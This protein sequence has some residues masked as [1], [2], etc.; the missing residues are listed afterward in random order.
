MAK[1][2]RGARP[3]ARLCPAQGAG[4]RLAGNARI[5]AEPAYRRLACRRA[6]VATLH[7]DPDRH[8]PDRRRG[9]AVPVADG[10]ARRGRAR[11]QDD[12]Q[13][14]RRRTRQRDDA[15]RRRAANSTTGAPRSD[16][17]APASTARWA[18]GTC[19]RS[20]TSAFKIVAV[21]P[22]ATGWEGQTL[23]AIVSGGQPL[24]MFGERAGVMEV[25]IDGRG[26]VR[27]AQ[28]DRRP[29]RALPRR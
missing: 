11:R 15:V 14:R 7:P 4:R 5:I 18:D 12:P 20:P 28:P 13:P 21:T 22:E 17:N 16:R 9:G 25:S 23:D 6:A 10:L 29:A 8:L 26:L 19:W 1:R 2:T 24:F 3:M 27:R